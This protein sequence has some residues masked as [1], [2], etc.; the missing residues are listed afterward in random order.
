[1]FLF[2]VSDS[3]SGPPMRRNSDNEQE[4]VNGSAY[5]GQTISGIK[6]QMRFSSHHQD[7]SMFVKV[8]LNTRHKKAIPRKNRSRNILG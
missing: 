5:G 4:L 8:N 2:L 3:D 6:C 7:P 1:M